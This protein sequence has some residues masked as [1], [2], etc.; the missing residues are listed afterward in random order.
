MILKICGRGW[1]HLI[2]IDLD[3]KYI[4]EQF[5]E[6]QSRGASVGLRPFAE[7]PNDDL[8]ELFLVMNGSLPKRGLGLS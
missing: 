3:E 8:I 2:K 5:A 1:I 7:D 4:S 6:Q